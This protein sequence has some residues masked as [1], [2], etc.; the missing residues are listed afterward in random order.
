MNGIDPK[1]PATWLVNC[2]KLK[3][4][5]LWKDSMLSIDFRYGG[6]SRQALESAASKL[7]AADDRTAEEEQWLAAMLETIADYQ[8]HQ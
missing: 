1:N 3:A 4:C 8:Q 7:Q 2:S 6:V 5:K